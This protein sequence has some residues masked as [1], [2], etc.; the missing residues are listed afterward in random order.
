MAPADGTEGLNQ[1]ASDIIGYISLS[2]WVV[3]MFPQIWLN[4]QRKS[5]EGVSTIMNI[6]WVI[7]DLFNITGAIM[8]NLVLSTILVGSY[9][10]LVDVTLLSQ[11]FYYR[12]FYNAHLVNKHSSE[13]DD[14]GEA[15]A[16]HSALIENEQQGAGNY[17]GYQPID[18]SDIDG[19]GTT[20]ALVTENQ[21]WHK[22]RHVQAVIALFLGLG[23]V[24]ALVIVVLKNHHETSPD[25][26]P[27]S[28]SPVKQIIAQAMGT[29]S[30]IVYIMSYVPQ[31]IQNYQR[32]SV[33]G[34]SVWLFILSLVGN[35][36]YALAILV[37]SL[38]PHYLAPYVPWLLGAL[39]PCI[40]HFVILYQF[41]IYPSE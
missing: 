29:V 9:Y 38:D 14:G 26:P 41:R 33:E 37:V 35:S 6:A 20:A 17:Q 1:T 32:K 27:G 8:Q 19:L 23:A 40:I 22:R 12:I 15:A 36:T 13:S 28:P 11:T 24:G 30:A 5:G 25:V 3:V 2:C 10:I 18:G 16:V 39:V 31:A 4:Y 7:G 21:P 34:L